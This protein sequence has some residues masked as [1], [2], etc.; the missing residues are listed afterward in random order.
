MYAQKAQ[1]L[2]ITSESS[3]LPLTLAS[4]LVGYLGPI[5]GVALSA[6]RHRP[7]DLPPRR[8][9]ILASLSQNIQHVAVLVDRPPQVSS[10]AWT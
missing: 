6:T 5:I 7:H 8:S 3:H 4:V 10:L 1:C 2:A 9:C